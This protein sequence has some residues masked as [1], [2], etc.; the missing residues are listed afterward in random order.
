M[1]F[2]CWNILISA[3]EN[4]RMTLKFL[5]PRPTVLEAHKINFF[6]SIIFNEIANVVVEDVDD[7]VG[8]CNALPKM[9]LAIVADP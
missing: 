6:F 1:N 2:E 7:V 4:V 3:F 8:D 9:D 5:Y